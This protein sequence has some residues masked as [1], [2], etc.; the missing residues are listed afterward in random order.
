MKSGLARAAFALSLLLNVSI[1]VV[2]LWLKFGGGLESVSRGRLALE[3]ERWTTQFEAL[4]V[5]RGDVVFLGDSITAG[6]RW[7]ELFP[8]LA[9][10]NRGIP[11]DRVPDVAARLSTIVAGQPSAVFLL[12]GTND[13]AYGASVDEVASGVAAILARF[14]RE[15]PDTRLHVQSVLPRS[16]EHA[17]RILALNEALERVAAEGEAQFVDLY[18]DFLDPGRNALRSDLSN[19]GLHLV[20]NGYLLWRSRVEDLVRDAVIDPGTVRIEEAGI[21]QVAS[22]ARNATTRFQLVNLWATWC[23]PCL[24]ELPVLVEFD[25]RYRRRGLD[26]VTIS[27]DDLGQ[28]EEALRFLEE[29]D[30]AMHNW[31]VGLVDVRDLAGALDEEWGGPLPY[32]VLIA[33]GGEIVYRKQGAFD[34]DVLEAEIL[35]QVGG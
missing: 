26:V 35:Q 17:E 19:D 23:T 15:S 30:A 16:A 18:G 21:E 34:R 27:I 25:R 14:R 33:P 2:V 31:I 29:I 11:G 8:G 10:R 6:G 32:T 12:I 20:A 7:Q 3:S 1:V 22:L 5:E 24:T 28:R 9:V 4:P 13:L